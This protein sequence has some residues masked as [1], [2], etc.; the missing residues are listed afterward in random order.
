MS[1]PRLKHLLFENQICTSHILGRVLML[2]RYVQFWSPKIW[3]VNSS[4]LG[5]G[6]FSKHCL[7][8]AHN[9]PRYFRLALQ[10]LFLY[11]QVILRTNSYP[12]EFT[13]VDLLSLGAIKRNLSISTRDGSGSIIKVYYLGQQIFLDLVMD[14]TPFPK[15]PV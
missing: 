4:L 7:I 10:S 6:T 13:R 12:N 15:K 8:L 1:F 3:I 2:A 9:H 14:V 5:R 11:Y